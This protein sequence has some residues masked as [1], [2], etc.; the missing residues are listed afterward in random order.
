MLR[1]AWKARRCSAK[2]R[3]LKKRADAHSYKAHIDRHDTRSL[4]AML[5]FIQDITGTDT[6]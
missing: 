4:D 3:G 6:P 1:G 5:C 2:S